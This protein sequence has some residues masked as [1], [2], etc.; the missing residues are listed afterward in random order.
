[1]QTFK[2]LARRTLPTSQAVLPVLA[3]AA[4]AALFL[5]IAGGIHAFYLWLGGGRTTG[6]PGGAWCG[7]RTPHA[8]PAAAIPDAR[9]D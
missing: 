5:L 3:F 8:H 1:M 6:A 4:S 7:T 9:L 2:L